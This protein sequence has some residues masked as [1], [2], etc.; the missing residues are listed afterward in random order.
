LLQ[1]TGIYELFLWFSIL[2][3]FEMRVKPGPRTTADGGHVCQ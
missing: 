2:K 1:Y 3:L